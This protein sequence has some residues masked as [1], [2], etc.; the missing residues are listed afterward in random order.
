MKILFYLFTA[1][2][3]AFSVPM[4]DVVP[5][6]DSTRFRSGPSRFEKGELTSIKQY[7]D[8]FRLQKPSSSLPNMHLLE[9]FLESV[10]PQLLNRVNSLPPRPR[11]TNTKFSIDK[12]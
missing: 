2:Q 12:T 11:A 8:E 1:T 9:P 4:N 6:G 7:I 3:L 10:D 5:L